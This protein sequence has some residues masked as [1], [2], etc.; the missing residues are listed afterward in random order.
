[1][2]TFVEQLAKSM[3]VDVFSHY[4]PFMLAGPDG[5]VSVFC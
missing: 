1:M 5:I 4:D 3:T 2:M